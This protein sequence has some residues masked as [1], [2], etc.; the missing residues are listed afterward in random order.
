[1]ILPK[2]GDLTSLYGA[3]GPR[4]SGS[5]NRTRPGSTAHTPVY[6]LIA[7]WSQRSPRPRPA[8]R[9]RRQP[10]VGEAWYRLGVPYTGAS[11]YDRLGGRAGARIPLRGVSAACHSGRADA[12]E[13]TAAAPSG[14]DP[15]WTGDGRGDA[16]GSLGRTQPAPLRGPTRRWWWWWWCAGRSTRAP[17]SPSSLTA[18]RGAPCP[19][20]VDVSQPGRRPWR[21]IRR[22]SAVPRRTFTAPVPTS[23]W[24]SS[25]SRSR[26]S[27]TFSEL[28]FPALHGTTY[29]SGCLAK[30]SQMSLLPSTGHRWPMPVTE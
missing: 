17:L 3:A 22:R 5:K 7:K 8:T 28:Q 13:R 9:S 6:G 20:N 14:A 18:L 11:H 29:G 27:P 16:A 25:S 21:P 24:R 1:M 19:N 2:V 23:R 26:S 15:Q 4:P 30:N 12:A 10:K